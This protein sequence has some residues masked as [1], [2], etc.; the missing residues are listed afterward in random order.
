MIQTRAHVASRSQPVA[1]DARARRLSRR[2]LRCRF[3]MSLR[4]RW[5]R[6]SPARKGVANRFETR[7]VLRREMFR[8]AFRI[9]I[10]IVSEIK[11]GIAGS[12]SNVLILPLQVSGR[13]GHNLREIVDRY[14]ARLQPRPRR[15]RKT[16]SLQLARIFAVQPA[17]FVGIECGGAAPDVIQIEKPDD[18][19][20]VAFSRGC[21]WAT[22]RAGRDNCARL[23]AENRS[24]CN[25]RRARPCRACSSSCRRGSG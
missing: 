6:I 23:R 13:R 5:H 17:Q 20:D 16:R 14:P 21:P 11:A 10:E 15:D 1:S 3:S 9:A 4:F 8:D 2:A 12:S 7:L 25:T 19:V 22:S 24:G 18:L